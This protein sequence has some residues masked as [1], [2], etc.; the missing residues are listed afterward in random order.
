MYI[1]IL[2][3][4]KDI[5]YVGTTRNY[6]RRFIEHYSVYEEFEMDIIDEF[7]SKFPYKLENLYITMF[8]LK[9]HNLLNSVKLQVSKK[10][11]EE[12]TAFLLSERI[13]K[14]I[15]NYIPE[16]LPKTHKNKAYVVS[17]EI[18]KK[19]KRNDCSNIFTIYALKYTEIYYAL[20][21]KKCQKE[22]FL[23]INKYYNENN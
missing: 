10:Q 8:R 13:F 7:D 12:L 19:V 3:R 6:E 16:K 15:L 23:A 20:K 9:G 18:L 22:V 11:Q 21:G 2:R 17:D 14:K 4:K 5:F 1:Y